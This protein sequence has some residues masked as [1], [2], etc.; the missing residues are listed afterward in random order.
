M[1]LSRFSYD[2]LIFDCDGTLV[3][4]EP[5]H[6]E[7]FRLALLDQ[8]ARFDRK[9]YLER[10]GLTRLEL[11]TEFSRFTKI[12]VDI[13][14]AVTSSEL[15]F[16]KLTNELDVI[17]EIAAIAQGNWKKVPMAVASSGQRLSVITSLES[18]GLLKL[19]DKIVTAEDVAE[20]KPLPEPYLKASKKL[21]ISPERCLVFEDTDQGLESARR[22]GCSV[23]DVRTI[24]AIYK[25]YLV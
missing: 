20:H 22:A 25:T 4:S 3:N 9:W 2:A 1:D 19:F 5:L 11:L 18:V 24:A 6:F 7:A 13:N 17:P 15:N 23:V 14:K 12:L 10:L 21:S 8:A 16:L